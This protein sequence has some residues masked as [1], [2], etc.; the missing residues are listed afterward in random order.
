V[1]FRKARKGFAG[2]RWTP[3][4]AP[5][6]AEE[7]PKYLFEELQA[8]SDHL[9]RTDKLHLERT[10]GREQKEGDPI[11]GPNKPNDG[12]IIYAA[13]GVVGEATGIYYYRDDDNDEDDGEWH[14]LLAASKPTKL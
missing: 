14:L 6:D 7:L 10:Y 1:S 11:E 5:D 2:V 3:K 9:T 12:D 13:I 8:L 4:I